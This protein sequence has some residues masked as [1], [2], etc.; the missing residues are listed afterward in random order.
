M[1]K[2]QPKAGV[3]GEYSVVSIDTIQGNP[4]N[5]NKQNNFIF[6]KL[7]ASISEYG[8]NDPII[9][10]RI[11]DE[12]VMY[13]VI[14]GHHRLKAAQKLGMTS[15]PIVDLGEMSD[16]KADRLMIVLNETKGAPD[17]DALPEMRALGLASVPE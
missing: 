3:S 13:E 11:A 12:G 14:G 16:V 17:A 15:V 9:V 1:A 6:S 8:L 7:V 10:R 4:R 5:P 2:K